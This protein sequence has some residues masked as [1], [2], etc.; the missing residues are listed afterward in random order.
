[1]TDEQL[2]DLIKRKGGG[3]TARDLVRATRKIKNTEQ[4]HI[5]L[6]KLFRQSKGKWLQQFSSN[7][8]AYLV[9]YLNEYLDNAVQN[10]QEKDGSVLPSDKKE[11]TKV[12]EKENVV[13]ISYVGEKWLTSDEILK[14]LNYDPAIWKVDK[15]EQRAWEVTGKVKQGDKVNTETQQK[16]RLP[17]KIWKSKNRYISIRL[18]RKLPK[19]I[20][21]GLIELLNRAKWPVSK[22]PSKHRIRRTN[23]LEMSIYDLH[24]GKYCWGKIT[25]EKYD[26]S[27][28]RTIFQNAAADLL[29]KAA[30]IAT[31]QSIVIPVG[32]DFFQVDNWI[33]ETAHGTVVDSCDD[34]FSKT[35][36][37]GV[38]AFRFCIDEC[39][40]VA[41]VELLYIPGNH[42]PSTAFYLCKVLE[43]AYGTNKHVYVDVEST[44]N[45]KSRK[46]KK[47]GVNLLGY[48]HGGRDCP[49]DRDLPLLMATECPGWWAQTI[50]RAWRLG[51]LHT[52]KTSLVP[53]GDVFNGVRIERIP[54]LSATDEWH[55]N[56]GF[57]GNRRAAEGWI[58]SYKEGLIHQ[59]PSYVEH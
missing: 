20:Q 26:V 36:A 23:L 46:Y 57:V 42:D 49:K 25:K 45:H 21:D 9:F 39:L 14:E 29:D 22:N 44:V 59:F 15:V 28:A 4:A 54:S 17:E 40:K 58:W 8:H 24:L 12:V 1:M 30:S 38:D 32:H 6:A 52:K 37:V 27:I 47:F 35:F 43:A 41:P 55:F 13:E 16:I 18:V 10:L 2:I 51:H 33:G 19:P 11:E 3:I 34:R 48:V 50:D 31:I 7:H 5:Y 53:I 56:N